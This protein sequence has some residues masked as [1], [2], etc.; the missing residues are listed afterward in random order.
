MNAIDK[1]FGNIEEVHSRRALSPDANESPQIG[2]R[3]FQNIHAEFFSH[4]LPKIEHDSYNKFSSMQGSSQQKKS[5]IKENSQ[6]GHQQKK[7][8]GLKT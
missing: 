4:D 8:L 7:D 1:L 3:P 2:Q 5:V 6:E